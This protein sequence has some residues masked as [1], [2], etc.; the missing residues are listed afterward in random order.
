MP[1]RK[2]LEGIH[3]GGLWKKRRKRSTYRQWRPRKECFGQMVQLDGSHHDWLEGS[4]K[5]IH[6]KEGGKPGIQLL[7]KR[8]MLINL[9]R[10]FLN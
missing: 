10:T 2:L 1:V 3:E 8:Y 6:G 4:Q 7:Q 5:T 9:N